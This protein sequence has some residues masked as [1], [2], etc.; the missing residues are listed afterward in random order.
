MHGYD[1]IRWHDRL[2]KMSYD[3]VAAQV[4]AAQE[5]FVSALGKPVKTFAAPGWQ[6]SKASRAVL[7]DQGF[8]YASD[9]RGEGPYRPRFGDKV[10]P[11][12]EIP[13]TLP[14]LDE[15]LG[16]HGCD[17]WDYYRL[18]LKRLSSARPHVL[19]LH[20]ELEG[21]PFRS[22][23]ADFLDEAQSRGITFFRLTDWAGELREHLEVLPVCRVSLNRLP[24]RAGR[25]ACQGPCEAP[26]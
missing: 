18:I 20:A 15:L 1:H 6:A 11:L 8:L 10:F 13:T 21:G 12:I 4:Q 9:T 26:A 2:V 16:F 14:T 24:G 23:F 5:V 25:V 7:A 22:N 19:T 3:E 17:A